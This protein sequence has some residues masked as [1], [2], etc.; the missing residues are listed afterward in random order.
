MLESMCGSRKGVSMGFPFERWTET[1]EK[2]LV[3]MINNGYS[4]A[5]CAKYLGRF[6][7]TL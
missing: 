2:E 7:A 5:C 3:W 1:Q 4:P 6:L